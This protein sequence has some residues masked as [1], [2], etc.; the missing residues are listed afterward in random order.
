MDGACVL[1][2]ETHTT[3]DRPGIESLVET[4]V[5]M[6]NAGDVVWSTRSSGGNVSI[7]ITGPPDQVHAV[8]TWLERE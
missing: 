7:T 6:A 1:I 3:R 8:M 2:S 4:I 5:T